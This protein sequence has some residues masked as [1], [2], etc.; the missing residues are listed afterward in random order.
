M[1]HICEHFLL[2]LKII[3]KYKNVTCELLFLNLEAQQIMALLKR[4]KLWKVD[5]INLKRIMDSNKESCYSLSPSKKGLLSKNKVHMS[6]S[7]LN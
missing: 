7:P 4:F 2:L 5:V 6:L 1:Q 3:F